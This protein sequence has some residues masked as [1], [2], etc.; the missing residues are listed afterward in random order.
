[1]DR[2][3]PHILANQAGPIDFDQVSLLAPPHRA[4]PLGEEPRD[5]RLPSPGIAA[6]DEVLRSR[7]LRQPVLETPRLDLQEGDQRAHLLLDGLEA[8]PRIEPR[9]QVRQWNRRQRLA[10]LVGYPVDRIAARRLAQPI[11]YYLQ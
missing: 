7:D 10:Q 6:E 8:D 9:L 3:R 1:L 4:V 5:R 2:R 11:A